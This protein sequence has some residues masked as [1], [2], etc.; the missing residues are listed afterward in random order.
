VNTTGEILYEFN[1][2]ELNA[3]CSN[4]LMPINKEAKLP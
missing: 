2:Q 4:H 3:K 1:I